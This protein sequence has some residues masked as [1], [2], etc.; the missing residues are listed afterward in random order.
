MTSEIDNLTTQ[1][2]S[3]Q[4]VKR[5]LFQC[6]GSSKEVRLKQAIRLLNM[7]TLGEACQLKHSWSIS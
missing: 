5:L 6:A 3:Q 7:L 1:I 4:K 2:Y